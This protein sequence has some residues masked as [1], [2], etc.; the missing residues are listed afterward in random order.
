MPRYT[1]DEFF[2][3]WMDIIQD[4][5]SASGWRNDLTGGDDDDNVEMAGRIFGLPDEA[6]LGVGARGVVFIV[7]GRGVDV[8]TLVCGDDHAGVLS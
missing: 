2:D 6:H 5:A 3:A 1:H 7:A 8:A 4:S